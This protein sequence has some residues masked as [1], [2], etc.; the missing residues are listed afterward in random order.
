MADFDQFSTK[1]ADPTPSQDS[2]SY[3]SNRDSLNLD[4]FEKVEADQVPSNMSPGSNFDSGVDSNTPDTLDL[5]A[6]AP[7]PPSSDISNE[8]SS[9]KSN[10][11]DFLSSG[12]KNSPFS[13]FMT[14]ESQSQKPTSDLLFERDLISDTQQAAPA[15]EDLLGSVPMTAAPPAAFDPVPEPVMKPEPTPPPREPTPPRREPTPPPREP[16]PPRQPTPPPREPT[17]PPRQ[18]TPP[19]REPTPPPRE[20]TPPPR[21]PTP[22]PRQPTPPPREPTPPPRQP[23]PPPREPTPPPRQ[24]TPPP[25]E[26][27]PPP[28]QPTPPR[29]PTP[30]PREPTPP[31]RQPTPPREA[32]PPLLEPVVPVPPKVIPA[33]I[34]E[35]R[36]TSGR[37]YQVSEATKA[38]FAVFNPRKLPKPFMVHLDSREPACIAAVSI[39]HGSGQTPDSGTGGAACDSPSA[40]QTSRPSSGSPPSR[41]YFPTG[42]MP[43]PTPSLVSCVDN[44]K[45]P[46]AW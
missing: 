1:A 14:Q 31:P 39:D 2:V 21:Q 30:P 35:A 28:R 33:P 29:E 42:Y 10:L 27:T 25:R 19:P 45:D 43:P 11:D 36:V 38:S 16:T 44:E 12:D 26:P 9:S 37:T 23:T 17:P 32:T 6:S 15:F 24:P 3:G 20:P 13:D 7:A 46:K 40:A 8:T 18:P 34:Q 4:D 5:I 41:K 22:P